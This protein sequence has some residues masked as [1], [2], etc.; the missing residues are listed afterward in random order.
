MRS[1]SFLWMYTSILVIILAGLSAFSVN[2]AVKAMVSFSGLA[3][4]MIISIALIIGPLVMLRPKWAEM[5]ESRRAIGLVG[6]YFIVLHGFLVS[7]SYFGFDI[8]LILTEIP[9][10]VGLVGLILMIPAAITSNDKSM[11][12]LGTK[13][14]KFLQRLVYL[15]IIFGIAHFLLKSDGL[16]SVDPA[17]LIVKIVILVA[18][19][20]QIIGFSKRIKRSK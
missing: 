4:L 7:Y 13:K 12:I 1:S 2:N 9:L 16:F 3:G 18:I 15:A 5:I 17:E 10:V 20:L 19:V 14:W 8:N 6:F 11:K